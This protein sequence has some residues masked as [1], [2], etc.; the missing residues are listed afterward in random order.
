MKYDCVVNNNGSFW[1]VC[2]RFIVVKKPISNQ[3]I[4]TTNEK[5]AL[6]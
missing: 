3:D 2:Y 5:V 6:L 4:E 1:L